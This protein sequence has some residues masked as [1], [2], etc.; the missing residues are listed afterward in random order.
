MSTALLPAASGT[1]L[2]VHSAVAEARLRVG[3]LGEMMVHPGF[4]LYVG[5]AYGPGG[6]RAR[7][8]RHIAGSGPLRWHIDYLRRVTQPVETWCAPEQRCEHE[9]ARSLASAARVSM[10]L[11]R[12]GAS[13]CRCPAHLFFLKGDLDSAWLLEC[14]QTGGCSTGEIVV[15]SAYDQ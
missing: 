3:S 6:L 4:Y 15:I 5:S 7:V 9:W 13:D 14:L 2:L 12:F 10:P 1:Y 8:G 11:A